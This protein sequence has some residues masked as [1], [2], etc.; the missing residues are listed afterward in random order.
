[1]T[2]PLC[3]R[4]KKQP[5]ECE[6]GITLYHADCRDVLSLLKDKSVD[7]VLTD[8][9][10][11]RLVG[12]HDRNAPGGVSKRHSVTKSVGMPWKIEPQEWLLET[13]R[14][15]KFGLQVFCSHHSVAIVRSLVKL[16][17]MCLAV[18]YKRNSTPT[19]KN[20]P[21]YT[22]EYIW[23]FNKSPG[24]KWDAFKSTLF[25][26]PVP[27]GGCMSKERFKNSDGTTLHPT[28]KPVE[29]IRQLLACGGNLVLDPF[30]GSGTTLRA[31]KDLGQKAIGIEIELKYVK[32]AAQ[33][34]KQEVLPFT[35]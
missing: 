13:E 1:M 28:Q 19:G 3:Y 25:D 9:P 21:R 5:C 16:K 22:T 35:D 18:W 2:L 34:L 32:I 12:G 14:I 29:L 27:C 7:L 31:A 30:A 23:W 17:P 10:Y 33:R 8:P 24:L 15:T 4:C 26:V 6:D 20:L 11:P